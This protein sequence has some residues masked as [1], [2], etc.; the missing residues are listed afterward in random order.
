VAGI[1][2]V[3]VVLLVPVGLPAIAAG[4]PGVASVSE[5][6]F[7]L[8]VAGG[9]AVIGFPAV[10]DVLAVASI[11]AHPGVPILAGGFTGLYSVHSVQYDILQDYGT[12]GLL[13]FSVFGLIF[14]RLEDERI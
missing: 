13:F 11:P 8:A 5:V 9:P 3:A 2:V 1:L 12:I 7:E 10:D 4:I 6:P 14:K